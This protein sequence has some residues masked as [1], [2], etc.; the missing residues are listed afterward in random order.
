MALSA[1][2]VGKRPGQSLLAQ[3]LQQITQPLHLRHSIRRGQ[4]RQHNRIELFGEL[5]QH[6]GDIAQ[7]AGCGREANQIECGSFRSRN[8]QRPGL[9]LDRDHRDRLEVPAHV[10]PDLDPANNSRTGGPVSDDLRDHRL[11]VGCP[12]ER[13]GTQQPD[14]VRLPEILH[15][16]I[17]EPGSGGAACL[18]VLYWNEYV[19]TAP[20]IAIRPRCLSR[21]S[22][23]SR[24][25]GERSW[26]WATSARVKV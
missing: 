15:Q 16:I 10:K 5:S 21:R 26:A 24:A 1:K 3:L 6:R 2:P 18:P 14:I 8:P 12:V 25:T 22:A 23:A 13:G 17:D 20:W 4:C 19:E 9:R 11:L 7:V